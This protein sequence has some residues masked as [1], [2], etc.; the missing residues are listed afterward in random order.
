M[1]RRLV[2]A[3]SGLLFLVGSVAEAA[4]PTDK[5]H[6]GKLK[7][8]AKYA[9]CRLKAES[10]AVLVGGTPDFSKCMSKFPAKFNSIETAAGIG[11]CPSEG[12]GASIDARITTDSNDIA[13]LLA[14]GTLSDCPT[15][16][17]DCNGDLASCTGDL[18]TCGSNLGDCESLIGV[19]KT[20]Q[21]ACYTA[22]G[23]VTACAGTGQDGEIQAGVPRSFTDNGD[24]TVTDN[25]TGLMWEKLSDDGSIHD[26]DTQYNW[27]NAIAGKIATL[28]STA[29]GGYTDWR[30]PNYYELQ[31]LIHLGDSAPAVYPEFNTGCVAGC[32]TCSCTRLNA[33][34]SSS[35]FDQARGSGWEINFDDGTSFINP[36]GNGSYVRAVR[37]GL[38]VPSCGNAIAEGSEEC[39]GIDLDGASCLSLGYNQGGTLGCTAG[40]YYDTTACA[41]QPF[42]ATGQ[43]TSYGTGDDGDVKAGGQLMYVDNDDGTIADVTTGLMWEKKIGVADDGGLCVDESGSCA[44]PHDGDNFYTWSATAPYETFDGSVVTIFLEQLNNRCNDDTTVSCTVD[45]DCAVPGGACGFAGHRDWR[46][47]NRKELETIVDLGRSEPPLVAPAFNG[48]SCGVLCTDLTNAACSC[49]SPDGPYWSSTTYA[50][51]PSGAWALYWEGTWE[52]GSKDIEMFARAV[53]GGS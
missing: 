48:A 42:P 1:Y 7:E 46:L 24:G 40:C 30:L 22:G 9:S 12:D 44:N 28:N 37:G 34:W 41:R 38:S 47:P 20:G 25:V 35:T 33:Y 13:I 21:T 39:D 17:A 6:S 3:V 2:V 8:S 11:V 14:G 53:R 36:K 4:D 15:D 29:F 50:I 19:L 51:D 43:T 32:A 26:K 18:A 23:A 52:P 10:K 5:C 31:T 45:A 16:L 49:T 27:T